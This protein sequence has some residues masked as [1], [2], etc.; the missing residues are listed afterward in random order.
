[1]SA[2]AGV[3]N[4]N[5]T[6]IPVINLFKVLTAAVYKSRPTVIARGRNGSLILAFIKCVQSKL[7]G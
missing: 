3:P 7:H 1:M 6:E 5:R 4:I 2:I